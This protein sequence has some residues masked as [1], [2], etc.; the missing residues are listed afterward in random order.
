MSVVRRTRLGF[1][2]I[3]LLVVIVILGILIAVAAPTFLR[4]QTR[5]QDSRT[6]Q[7]LATA[8][9]AIGTG[10]PD[11]N[12]LY[13]SS[14][15]MVSWIQQ[16]EPELTAQRG[17][18]LTQVQT[19]PQDAVLVDPSSTSTSLELCA[20]SQSG[21]VWKL[22][23]SNTGVQQ[24]LD[25]TLVP[26]TVSG[27][28]ITD[29][30]RVANTQGDGL[31][32]DSS[33]GIW[34]G[35]TNLITNGGF[36]T[37]TTGWV[38]NSAA[39]ISRDVTVSK[40]GKASLKVVPGT[41]GQDGA[42]LSAGAVVSGSTTYTLSAWVWGSGVVMFA[43]LGDGSARFS[44]QF[45]LSSTPTRITYT[46]TTQ[47]ATTAITPNIVNANVVQSGP[48]WIDGVQLEQKPYATPYVETSGATKTRSAA[49]VQAPAGLIGATQSW[50]ALR[51]RYGFASNA[52]STMLG[53]EPFYWADD[54]NN[55]F[56]L[57]LNTDNTWNLWRNAANLGPGATSPAQTFSAGDYVTL[58]AY[59]TATQIG[60]SVNGSPFTVGA[61]AGI[62]TLAA[63]TFSIG[64]RG[65]GSRSLDGDV[66]WFACGTGTL[67][68]PDAATING[69]GNTDPKVASFP[70]G[71]QAT[72]VWDGASSSGSLK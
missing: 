71:A 40:F 70:A 26:L 53:P 17:S 20:R 56:R 72:M 68:N 4:Q 7:Y 10:T 8:Y 13:P 36:E 64:S 2:L 45:T 24:L 59:W 69:F 11:A 67:S 47:P 44:G 19:A 3:E 16:S 57:F 39:T 34:E 18:C 41:G 62:P 48:Y 35:T 31:A 30:T 63:T 15:S 6:Q 50:I 46:W 66:L 23:A 52:T 51:I 9:K 37:N 65:D 54:T 60:L 29:A 14:T 12:N 22:T 49:L 33:T 1:T 21:N 27:N 38:A 43:V 28:E 61:G 25:G 42:Q 55:R 58:I 32:N 5:A